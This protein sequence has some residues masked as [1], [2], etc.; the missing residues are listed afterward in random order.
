M[1]GGGRTQQRACAATEADRA[2][3]SARIADGIDALGASGSESGATL[4]AAGVGDG[5]VLYFV[6]AG[7]G[8]GHFNQ[9]GVLNSDD[10]ID[11][12]SSDTPRV[13]AASPH[14]SDEPGGA[15]HAL[16]R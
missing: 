3:C 9:E 8:G 14:G 4:E 10:D 7:G 13:P 15:G 12:P 16:K 5:A 2:G 11:S 1:T 6:L